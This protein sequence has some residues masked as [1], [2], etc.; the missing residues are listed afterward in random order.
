VVDGLVPEDG[1]VQ[2]LLVRGRQ[3]AHRVGHRDPQHGS[4]G[5][6]VYGHVRDR[7]L[8]RFRGPRPS[9]AVLV[10]DDAP[11]HGRQPRHQRWPRQVQSG[12][13]APGADHGLLDDVLGLLPV[14]AG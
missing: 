12:R 11:G 5:V 2:Y 4:R 9:P 3:P 7:R 13:L 1:L 6:I 10:D 8:L 14:P